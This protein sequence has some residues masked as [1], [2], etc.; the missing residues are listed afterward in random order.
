VN[1]AHCRIIQQLA[2]SQIKPDPLN[3]RTHSARQIGQIANSI[4]VFGF[5]SPLL[6]TDDYEL[7]AGEGRWRAAME[8]GLSTVPVIVV[9]GLSV[10]KRRA[11]AIADNKI[12]ENAR[13]DRERLAIVIPELAVSLSAEG[14][15][16]SVLGFEPLEVVDL[17]TRGE[18]Q[19]TDRWDRLDP[20]WLQ[21]V[22]VTAPND[23]WL[24]GQHKILCGE[25]CSRHDIGR[26]MT[27]CRADFAFLDPL[28]DLRGPAPA[29][30][31]L[32]SDRPLSA[33]LHA[34]AS[35]S[36]AGAVHFVCSDQR[37]LAVLL[38]EA[39]P[40]YGKP[41]DVAVWAKPASDRG[42]LY[43][44]QIEFIGV[45]GVGA[46]PPTIAHRRPRSNLWHHAPVPPRFDGDPSAKPVALIGDAIK[47]CTNKG[48]LSRNLGDD[49][50]R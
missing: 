49:G 8:I 28:P 11:L 24:M 48:E 27:G 36:R 29:C 2:T 37:R 1:R 21:P 14:L 32:R 22:A 50:V 4:L 5:T 18:A 31:N 15:D 10:A 16:V 41:I 39:V 25:P 40:L 45:F 17:Q 12:A 30:D 44:N 19:A 34:A 38:A 35:V 7:I 9:A 26:L 13:W 20:I 43:R 3:A 23:L 42:S 47:D 6:V 33:V 46:T